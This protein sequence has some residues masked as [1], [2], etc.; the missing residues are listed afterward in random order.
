MKKLI[1]SALAI[2]AALLAHG[3]VL[4][5]AGTQRIALPDGYRVDQANIAPDGTYA[6]ISPIS[7]QG[8]TRLDLATGQTRVLAPTG[9]NYDLKFTADSRNIVYKDVTIGKDNLR[10]VAVKSTD[11]QTAKTVTL[12]KPSRDIQGISVNGATAAAI[13]GGR[14]R[15]KQLSGA[16]APTAERPELSIDRG[17]LMITRGGRTQTLSPLG[18]TG[19]SYIWQSL[20]PNGK[21][22]LFYVVGDGCYTCD[23][24]GT[25]VKSLGILRAPV[26]YDDNTIVG[27]VNQSDGYVITASRLVASTADG[28]ARQT[29][30]ADDVAAI[31]P[32]TANGK[33]AFSTPDGQLYIITIK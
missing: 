23:L 1:F 10:R 33:I 5:V 8:L 17:Q 16:V 27:M 28:T 22:V 29:L 24:D 25:N 12:V 20:S 4:E 32:S 31:Y 11:V 3:Q 19:K 30:T 18:T 6:V 26:W 9:S 14:L 7:G 2:C 15:T 13:D 21:R